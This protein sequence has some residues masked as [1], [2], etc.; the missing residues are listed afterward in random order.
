MSLILPTQ[1]VF[2]LDISDYILRLINIENN[3]IVSSGEVNVPP[4]LINNGIIDK[5]E[6][7]TQL[8]KKML[9]TVKGKKIKTKYVNACLPE[10]KTF[11]KVIILPPHEKNDF[12]AVLAEEITKNIPYNLEEIY[13]DW[14]PVGL[15]EE[16][17]ILVGV[18]PKDIVNSYQKT[19]TA[20]ELVPLALEIEAASI[21]RC[22]I[23][24][25]EK[26]KSASIILD[27]GFNRTG[28]IVYDH[29]TVQFSISIPISGDAITKTIAKT[30]NLTYPEA[31]KAKNICG[32]DEKKC[33]RALFR[34]LKPIMNNLI[35]KINDAVI[36]YQNHF[37]GSQEIKKIVLCGGGANFKN[38]GQIITA[39]TGLAVE[40]ANI[41]INLNHEPSPNLLPKNKYLSYISAIGLALRKDT[42]Y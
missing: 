38:F 10:Q 34:I 13:I 22:L 5:P 26:E 39:E 14:Q 15:P 3:Q 7:V 20:A 27:L 1:H 4:G 18:A 17:K 35:N 12:D 33:D 30:L 11:I 8:I 37:T 25:T 6:K 19:L 32:F 2:G 40:K 42:F 28:L 23:K 9:Q 31:E 24:S 36:F 21:S 16:N 29:Q 41:L